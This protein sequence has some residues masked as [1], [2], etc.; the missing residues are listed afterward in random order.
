[1]AVQKIR[2]IAITLAGLFL[3]S[4]CAAGQIAATANEKATLDGVDRHLGDI[5][6]LGLSL[7]A[8]A[9]GPSYAP[10]SNI[11]VNMVLVNS[12]H[13]TDKL[14]S[15][16]STAAKSWAS[17]APAAAS[18]VPL[19]ARARSLVGTGVQIPAGSR[20]QSGPRQRYQLILMQSTRR[21]WPGTIVH[22]V[23]RFQN[24]GTIDVP[25]PIHLTE[26]GPA[27]LTVP[28]VATATAA[29]Q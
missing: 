4:A 2:L 29:G 26:S 13:R 25:V 23:F 14:V 22:V 20:V 6:L 5:G 9:K 12:G 28:P 3:A 18:T 1:V 7:A 15:I 11:P 17:H 10:G 27:G 19:T 24:A 8:P 16:T 21:L